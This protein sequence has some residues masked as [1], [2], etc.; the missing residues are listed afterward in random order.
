MSAGAKLEA[1]IAGGPACSVLGGLC[2][3]AEGVA[4]PADAPSL[5]GA[6]GLAGARA[7]GARAAELEALF[8]S[9]TDAVFVADE[10]GSI[11]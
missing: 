4:G 2:R 9:L 3:E 7:A 10:G 11:V 5:A 8:E 1:R 6:S